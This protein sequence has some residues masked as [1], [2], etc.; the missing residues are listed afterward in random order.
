MSPHLPHKTAAPVSPVIRHRQT[1][2][3]RATALQ[4]LWVERLRDYSL[5]SE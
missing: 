5:C 4:R 2:R 1:A 3:H